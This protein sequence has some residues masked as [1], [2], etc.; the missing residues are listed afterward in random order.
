[1]ASDELKNATIYVDTMAVQNYHRDDT[2]QIVTKDR[3][4][5]FPV[6][7]DCGLK[8]AIM[9]LFKEE[10]KEFLKNNM[11]DA[12]SLV[13]TNDIIECC[14]LLG[15]KETR[16][17]YY[18]NFYKSQDTTVEHCKT[19]DKLESHRDNALFVPNPT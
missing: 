13:P 10:Q 11:E 9:T 7:K 2:F 6:L 12:Y 8:V 4:D 1:M 14:L 16:M 18:E 3:K 15:G 5:K 19:C 17:A